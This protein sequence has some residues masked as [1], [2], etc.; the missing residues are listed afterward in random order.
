[1]KTRNRLLQVLALMISLCALSALGGG[2][3]GSPSAATTPRFTH[4]ALSSTNV[5]ATGPSVDLQGPAAL[6]LPPLDSL[7]GLAS[8][9]KEFMRPGVDEHLRRAALK[10]LFSDPY[11]NAPDPF[12]AYSGDFTRGEPIPAAMLR[13][14]VHAKGLLFD[15]EKVEP[16]G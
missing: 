16:R 14:I 4:V 12:E 7:K 3:D 8:D 13:T 2:G 5:S 1:M 10:K 11:F 9:Y 15:Q 6:E